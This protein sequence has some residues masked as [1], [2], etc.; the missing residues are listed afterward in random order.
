VFER[1]TEKARRSIFFARYEAGQMGSPYIEIE[2]M[3]LGLLREEKQLFR[4][5]EKT[6]IDPDAMRAEVARN[7]PVAVKIET[8]V[9]LPLSYKA[10]RS[11]AYGAEEAERLGHKHI[12]SPH[13]LL[14]LMRQP[15]LATEILARH[16]I[17]LDAAR[18]A[19]LNLEPSSQPPDRNAQI[20]SQLRN[21]FA[22]LA[23]QLTPE[24]E[25][26]VIYHL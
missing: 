13:L 4:R 11:L 5:L 3:L 12:G 17:T 8:S 10:K 2:H 18:L 23:A 6:P 15:S 24:V 21:E 9:D 7:T 22:P 20:V 19:I 26:V 16:G 1:Y 25:P 14:G